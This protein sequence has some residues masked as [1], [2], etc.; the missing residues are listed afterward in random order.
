MVSTP[1]RFLKLAIPLFTTLWLVCL[2]P[3]IW[4]GSLPG[5]PHSDTDGAFFPYRTALRRS[6]LA[7]DFPDLVAGMFAGHAIMRHG[8]PMLLYPTQLAGLP[9]PLSNTRFFQ[10]DLLLHL[11]A[12]AAGMGW[13]L[14]RRGHR[15]GSALA[16]G[17]L[18]SASGALTFRAHGHW[19]MLHQAAVLPWLMGAWEALDRA[20][21]AR[22]AIRRATALAAC[23]GLM[24][25]C[26]APQWLILAA[27]ILGALEAGRTMRRRRL[28]PLGTRLGLLAG[29]AMLAA[30][31]GSAA[32]G[33]MAAGLA[34]SQ[35]SAIGGADVSG[36][37]PL[38]PVNL[39]TLVFP[40]ALFGK[41]IGTFHGAW[42]PSES[43]MV[44][45]RAAIILA[46]GGVLAL[47]LRR[48]ALLFAGRGAL[49]LAS[50]A[51]GLAIGIA[52]ATPLHEFLAKTVPLYGSFRAWGRAGTFVQLGL[53]VLAAEGLRAIAVPRRR[54]APLAAMASLAAILAASAGGLL[55]WS[56]ANAQGFV[57][58]LRSFGLRV[59]ARDGVAVPTDA[60]MQPMRAAFGAD[61]AWYAAWIAVVV[62]AM[63]RARV[64]MVA[65]C[66][67]LAEAILLQ[68]FLL[69]PRH[70][71]VL[72]PE[73]LPRLASVIRGVRERQ[74]PAPATVVFANRELANF[75]AHFDGVR[76][77]SGSDSQVSAA[78][79]DWLNRSQGLEDGKPQMDTWIEN[80]TPEFSAT[81]GL[82]T[83]VRP[84]SAK[85]PSELPRLDGYVAVRRAPEPYVEAVG[86]NATA[87]VVEW[88]DGF[89]RI[90]ADMGDSGGAL[91]IREFP[92]PLWRARVDGA[93]ASLEARE[94]SLV[95]ALEG[96]RHLV[97]L[98]AVDSV[99]RACVAINAAAWLGVAGLL[100]ATRRKWRVT[101]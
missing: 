37:F 29:A 16:L 21:L 11:T 38:S 25:S 93:P 45:G 98:K 6:I 99:A 66:I 60:Y 46:F 49:P 72:E 26:H 88:T 13:M 92:N 74:A 86:A 100:L 95:L 5:P 101:A 61:V 78:Y 68:A 59:P 94:N 27:I 10:L 39:P 23:A 70:R 7:G 65:A 77:L 20:T 73:N 8:Q 31:L 47:A 82:S 89:V 17:F 96:G 85:D 62:F 50:V 32:L 40:R 48:R 69:T 54:R 63:R 87:K 3:M 57:E 64:A 35:R 36:Q 41:D 51:V 90:E 33:P 80:P 58:A 83:F 43:A 52:P 12:A 14:A 91:R 42:L 71:G 75:A 97:E 28:V 56:F 53:V 67:V 18:W 79:A 15:A 55:A 44:V 19:T 34:D 1:A 76:G 24:V 4:E 22:G 9:L 2:A 30:A 84:A 81:L